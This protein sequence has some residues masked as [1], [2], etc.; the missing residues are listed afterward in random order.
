MRARTSN[1]LNLEGSHLVLRSQCLFHHLPYR[2]KPRH[3]Q[4]T[5]QLPRPRCIHPASF[6]RVHKTPQSERLYT[7]ALFNN[8]H[9]THLDFWEASE[10]GSRTDENVR[11]RDEDFGDGW[12]YNEEHGTRYAFDEEPGSGEARHTDVAL[13]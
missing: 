5:I 12:R 7:T 1:H 4:V 11:W 10:G 6:L 2:L 9:C 3:V 8:G 13:C